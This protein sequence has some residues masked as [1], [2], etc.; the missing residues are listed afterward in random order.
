MQIVKGPLG[1]ATIALNFFSAS[2]MSCCL[3]KLSL[4]IRLI[5]IVS[6]LG[7]DSITSVTRRYQYLV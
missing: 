2:R 6:V 1:F 7:K 3:I 4:L 5:V